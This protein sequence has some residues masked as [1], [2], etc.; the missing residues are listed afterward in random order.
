MP[1]ETF[2]S[3]IREATRA[4]IEADPYFAAVPVVTEKVKDFIANLDTTLA[5]IDGLCI[6]LV[7]PAVGECLVNVQGAN[8]AGIKLVARIYE[9]PTLN[10]TGK[11]ALDAA[12]YLVALLSQSKP[13]SLA[14]AL[15]PDASPIV[16]SNDPKYLAYDV[17][18]ETEGGMKI[19]IPRLSTPVVDANNFAA[20]T[21]SQATPGAAT[22][23][24][25]DGSAPTPRNP[26]A[27]LFL[28]PFTANAGQTLRART[29]LAGYIPSPETKIVLP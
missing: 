3:D 20:I 1:N 15:K 26:A 19:E 6:V 21:L 10:E 8:F 13:D 9:S 24:T 28:A 7:T 12:I 18:F 29:W 17:I 25:L 16:L 2:L 11:A 22:F 27:T 14:A 5:Q 23:Y 4:L